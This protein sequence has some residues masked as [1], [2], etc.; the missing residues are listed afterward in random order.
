MVE[1]FVYI[2][3]VGGPNPSVPTKFDKDSS[4]WYYESVNLSERNRSF[5]RKI[6][7]ASAL[8]L[9][10]Q[11]STQVEASTQNTDKISAIQFSSSQELG[12]TELPYTVDSSKWAVESSYTSDFT[13]SEDYRVTNIIAGANGLNNWFWNF[14]G[15]KDKDGNLNKVGNN[16]IKPGESFSIDS[17]LGS[18]TDYVTGYA[19]GPNLEQIPVNGGGICQ[20]STTLFV[21]SLK[22]GLYVEDR[23]NHSYYNGWYFGDPNDPKEFGMDATVEIPGAD[24]VVRNTYDYPIR[25]FFRVINEHLKVDV[26]GP[27]ELKPYYAELDGPYFLG[28]K[29]LVKKAGRYP[30]AASTIVTQSV[31]RD[32]S[33]R[34][35]LFTKPFRSYY[36]DSPYG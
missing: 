34:E 25:F 3:D 11:A 13:G 4:E 15:S 35:L 24:L 31:W 12:K 6:L 36:Q 9:P 26:Y 17:V 16:F 20:I 8:L 22:S 1:R 18:V 2:E 33:K 27:P 19:I 23:I 29:E 32:K 7:L 28:T 21:T 30:W 14:D 5:V 10:L